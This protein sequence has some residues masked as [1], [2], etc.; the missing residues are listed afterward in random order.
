M[1]GGGGVDDNRERVSMQDERHLISHVKAIKK[2]SGEIKSGK[3]VRRKT[4][5]STLAVFQRRE[6]KDAHH[7]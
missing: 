4:E 6:G 7:V 2:P 3:I 1:Q 5:S